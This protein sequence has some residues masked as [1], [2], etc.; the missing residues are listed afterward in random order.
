MSPNIYSAGNPKS[1]ALEKD[2]RGV[3]HNCSYLSY[4]PTAYKYMSSKSK[5]SKDTRLFSDKIV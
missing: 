4:F 5:S 1:I 2:T 3:I